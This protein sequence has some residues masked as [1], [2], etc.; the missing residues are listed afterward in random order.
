MLFFFQSKLIWLKVHYYHLRSS[1]TETA[2]SFYYESAAS[3]A[4]SAG[5]A[6]GF[7]IPKS[8]SKYESFDVLSLGLEEK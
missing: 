1:W 6:W 7:P 3:I 4:D 8:E 5:Q 2:V